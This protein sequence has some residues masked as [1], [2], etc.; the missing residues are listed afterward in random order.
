MTG[1]KS[2][3]EHRPCPL[4]G[5][6]TCVG[7]VS[8]APIPHLTAGSGPTDLHPEF[9]EPC[10]VL[11]LLVQNRQRE[12]V[13]AMVFPSGVITNC[14]ISRNLTAFRAH[15]HLKHGVDIRRVLRQVRRRAGRNIVERIHAV[16]QFSAQFVN[17]GDQGFKMVA[18]LDAGVLGDLFQP[19]TVE[20]D[21]V[22]PQN[23]VVL[24]GG[25]F[26][27]G[28][29]QQHVQKFVHVDP[30]FLHY[31]SGYSRHNSSSL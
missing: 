6:G 3:I 7:T 29:T 23:S 20:S 25:Q 14:C 24:I 17:A 26:S 19:F 22:D 27:G 1:H 2:A 15:R 31:L 18:V 12:V 28:V 4:N 21:Q 13:G 8:F 5:A 16:G 10:F 30:R 9:R 11:D